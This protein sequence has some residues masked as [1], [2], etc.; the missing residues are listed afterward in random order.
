MSA[1]KSVA[2]RESVSMSTNPFARDLAHCFVGLCTLLENL[3]ELGLIDDACPHE[4]RGEGGRVGAL[5][6]LGGDDP[7]LAKEDDDPSSWPWHVSRPLRCPAKMICSKSARPKSSIRPRTKSPCLQRGQRCL[8]S[9]L[10]ALWYPLLNDS[11]RFA[12]TLQER[13]LRGRRDVA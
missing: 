11:G 7:R 3:T 12:P 6:T 13:A 2:K 4:S 1:A 5:R 8:Y 9:R 10:S